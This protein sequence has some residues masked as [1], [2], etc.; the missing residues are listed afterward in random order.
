[1]R[2]GIDLMGGDS[3]PD[4]L[5]PAVLQ[6]AERLGV[7]HSL[8][9]IATK[10]VVDHLANLINVSKYSP[11]NQA[12]IN[13]HIV[14]DSIAMADEPLGAVRRKKEASLVVGMRLLKKRQLD[15][16]VSCGN[17]G[18]LIASAALSLPMMSGMKRPALLALLPTERKSVAVLDIGG[19]ISCKAR[20]LVQFAYLGAAYQRALN[21]IEIPSIGLLNVGVE[22]TKGTTEVRQAYEALK[23]QCENFA[24]Q[25]KGPRMTFVGNIEGR[26][27]FKGIVDVLVTDGFTG[28]VLLKTAE[29]VASFIFG[30]LNQIIKES[31]FP[32]AASL[33]DFQK[34]FNYAEYPGAIVCGV[35]GVVVKV[36]GSASAKALL[37]SILG[38]ARCVQK[39]AV[40]LI[41]E[42]IAQ[43]AID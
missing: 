24:S 28:N 18:A 2:I 34:Q 32:F 5:F 16:F 21:G 38:A 36:H 37:S 15:A 8:L 33:E 25:E 12:S 35:D 1:L 26:D 43:Q 41:K 27:V 4:M 3:P 19:N 23:T 14:A 42:Q 20:H 40:A 39:Q 22:S 13:F 7:S 9:V 17:T 31:D 6:A 11:A 30:A 10:A 29:G